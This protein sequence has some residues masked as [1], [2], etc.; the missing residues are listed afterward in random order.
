MLRQSGS[1]ELLQM[2]GNYLRCVSLFFFREWEPPLFDDFDE[3]DQVEMTL[4][5]L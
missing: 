2:L 3:N 5:E 1:Q 4:H